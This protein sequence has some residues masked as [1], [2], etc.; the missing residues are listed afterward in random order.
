VLF[1]R[2]YDGKHVAVLPVS[3]LGSGS[4]YVTSCAS[5]DGSIV[6]RGKNDGEGPISERKVQVIIAVSNDPFKTVAAATNYLK[7][8]IMDSRGFESTLIDQWSKLE[9][10]GEDRTAWEDGLSY[11]TWNGIGADLSEDKIL[12][13]LDELERAGVRSKR[14]CKITRW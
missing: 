7:K 14:S 8:L 2:S 11:C 10:E 4:A 12:K 3:G 13:A 5:G 6:I 1:Q 9:L